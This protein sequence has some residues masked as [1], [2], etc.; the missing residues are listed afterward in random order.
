LNITDI[1]AWDYPLPDSAIAQSPAV[2]RDSSRLLVWHA[3]KDGERIEHR[4]FSDVA[5]YLTP[6]DLLVLNDTRVIPAR[7]VGTRTGGGRAEL[8]LLSPVQAGE[9]V[10][11]AH[12]HAH[13]HGTW[14]ALVRPG[15]RLRDGDSVLV[16][17]REIKIIATE[18]DGVRVVEVGASKEDVTAFLDRYGR[19]PLPP[20]I[21]EDAGTRGSFHA[22]YQTVFAE[23]DGSAAAPTAGL[24]FTLP[25]LAAIEAKGVVNARVTLHVGLGTFRPVKVKDIREHVVHSEY[26]E[27]SADAAEAVR[28]CRERGGRV[29]AVGTTVARTLES[30]AD[31]EGLVRTGAGETSL[32]IRP[33][34]RWRVV[35]ALITNFHLPKS[36]LLMLVASFVGQISGMEDSHALA[37]L[38]DAY[39]AALAEGY[40]FF[41]FGDAMMIK[42]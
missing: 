28:R 17:D 30:H 4:R 40:R 31:S 37:A 20:Y 32:F 36:S 27:V 3:G 10:F 41:S 19:T 35:D 23:R 34:F 14:R 25:L 39:A 12:A 42:K 13:A 33:G 7:L 6:R 38:K 24:H 1:N 26:C 9:D 16:G 8:L 21:K 2:P 29:V 22:A 11:C 18:S 5:D 15:R